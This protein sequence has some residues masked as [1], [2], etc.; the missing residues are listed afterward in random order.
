M[1]GSLIKN[2][3]GGLAPTGGYIV[4]REDLV[5]DAA[6]QLTAPGLGDHMGSLCAWLSDY[7]SKVYLWL[8]M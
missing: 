8:L 6:Y 3:G 2:A 7:S 5:E 4:G 1:A